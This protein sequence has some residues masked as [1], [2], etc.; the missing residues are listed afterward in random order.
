[1][2]FDDVLRRVLPRGSADAAI[3]AAFDEC[4]LDPED[5]LFPGDRWELVRFLS[6][7]ITWPS[8]GPPRLEGFAQGVLAR[9]PELDDEASE[10]LV[11]HVESNR[12]PEEATAILEEAVELF[13]DPMNGDEPEYVIVTSDEEDEGFVVLTPDAI[14]RF[15]DPED[16]FRAVRMLRR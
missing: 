11:E 4:G 1:M 15:G 9:Y 14:L 7:E 3:A 10:S 16:L 8:V 13:V 5:D 6:A 12:W 2:G